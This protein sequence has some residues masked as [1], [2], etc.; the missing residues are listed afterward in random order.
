MPSL[1]KICEGITEANTD[2]GFRLWM[3]SMPSTC[4]PTNVLQV[5]QKI[6]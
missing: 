4:F 1:D 3:T 5:G 2:P 6:K